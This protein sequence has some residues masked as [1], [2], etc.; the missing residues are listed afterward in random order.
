MINRQ[1]LLDDF[2]GLISINS[3]S[4]HEAE[5]ARV[6][7]HKLEELSFVVHIDNAGEYAGSDT[8]NL[9]ARKAGN[10]PNAVPILFSAHMDTVASTEGI[11]Y[12]VSD[13]GIIS[14][15]GRTILGADDKAGIAAILEGLKVLEENRLPHGDIEIVFSICEEI[16]LYGARHLDLSSIKSKCCFVYDIGA[17]VGAIIIAAPTH[18]NIEAVVMGKAAHAGADPEN[19]INAIY[20]ASLAIANMKLGRID[21]ETTAN[22]GII[23]GGKATNIVPDLC[24]VKGEARSLDKSKLESQIAQMK[25]AFDQAGGETGARIDMKVERSYSGYNLSQDNIAFKIAM[26]A[27]R[28]AGI[29]PKVDATGGGS[30]ANIFNEHGITAVPIGVGYDKP[31]TNEEYIA[32][33]DLVL[34]AKMAVEIARVAAEQS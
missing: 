25:R 12:M 28:R 29:S 6:L 23:T 5:I 27:A 1:R 2:L 11:N 13:D 4:R 3:P 7:A 8:G 33:N 34:S 20:A 24:E 16:G 17:P 15:D 32:I 22:I 26:E 18:D 21:Q 19:G 31:H 10:S 30:D 9:I 14:T